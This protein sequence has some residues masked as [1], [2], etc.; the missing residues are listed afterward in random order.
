MLKLAL[1]FFAIS[2]AR[3]FLVFPACRL[4]PLELQSGCSSQRSL[5]FVAFL[6]LGLLA[7]EVLF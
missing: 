4:V 1:V 6:V 7:G 5:F 3:G 2:V